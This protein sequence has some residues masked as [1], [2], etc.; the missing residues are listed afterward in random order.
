M[1]GLS[2]LGRGL[3]AGLQGVGTGLHS[4]YNG[5]NSLADSAA[6]NAGGEMLPML[7]IDPANM[8]DA[9]RKQLRRS[10][11]M[12]FGAGLKHGD[13]GEGIGGYQDALG[14]QY[15][16]RA[17]NQN[18]VTEADHKKTLAAIFSNKSLKP[19]E[20]YAQASQAYA[21][22]G[23]AEKAVAYA[24]LAPTGD[25]EEFG[26]T[27]QTMMDNRPGRKPQPVSVLVGKQG[28]IKFLDNLAA[29]AEKLTSVDSGDKT[30]FI[31]PYTGKEI[32]TLD[33]N[34]TKGEQIAHNDRAADAKATAEYRASSL[35][36]GNI[37]EH[38]GRMIQ[39]K[40]DPATNALSVIELMDPATGKPFKTKE[41]AASYTPFVAEGG[42][43]FLSSNKGGPMRPA[44]DPQGNQ[45]QAKVSGDEP[46]AAIANAA[47]SNN[48]SMRSITSALGS[49][50]KAPKG[51]VGPMN[52]VNNL[53]GVGGAVRYLRD[54]NGEDAVAARA[55]IADIRALKIHDMSGA[56]TSISEMANLS[57]FLPDESLDIET[58]KTRLKGLANALESMNVDIRTGY[59]STNKIP[60]VPNPF[61]GQNAPST[62]GFSSVRDLFAPQAPTTAPNL[63]WRN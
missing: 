8:T 23:D 53:Y 61:R 29:P 39:L 46:P 35:A 26:T 58:N 20:Q 60:Q 3:K 42:K 37:Q 5:L 51:T 12:N 63:L 43:V 30:S 11:L 59:P 9:Q 14:Q 41:A 36:Q 6:M 50:D 22:W 27:P 17:A 31:D 19:A 32:G 18:R 54:M 38:D 48:A 52:A 24:K 47:F 15:K 45:I 62:G 21:S 25:A 10:F 4:A 44:V 16:V 34:A 7:G 49:L 56:A 2:T 40:L 1:F 13:V 55:A 28:T 33:K 57:P